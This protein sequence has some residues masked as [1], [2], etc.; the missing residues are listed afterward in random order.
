MRCVRQYM[1]AKSNMPQYDA[2]Y[3]ARPPAK[4]IIQKRLEFFDESLRSTMSEFLERFAGS[5]EEIE[6]AGQFATTIGQ[7]PRNSVMLKK[8]HWETERGYA[9]IPRN[10]W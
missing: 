3:I 10:E 6:M 1:D 5:G 7:P 9:S 4:E 2:I 8:A